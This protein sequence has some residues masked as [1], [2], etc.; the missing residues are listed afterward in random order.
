MI[1][2]DHF[3]NQSREMSPPIE[4]LIVLD[5]IVGPDDDDSRMGSHVRL[6]SSAR[7]FRLE[8]LVPASTG[9]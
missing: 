2:I 8:L 5:T 4:V 1:F 3:V 9:D 7:H 6:S